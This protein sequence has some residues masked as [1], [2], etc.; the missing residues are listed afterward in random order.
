MRRLNPRYARRNRKDEQER[1][2]EKE[3]DKSWMEGEMVVVMVQGDKRDR[4]GVVIE[5]RV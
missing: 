5:G 1:L 3:K 2:K 4:D